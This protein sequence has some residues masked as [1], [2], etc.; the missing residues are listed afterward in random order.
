MKRRWMKK[1]L[2]L[3]VMIGVAGISQA[4]E[5]VKDGKASGNIYVAADAAKET[6]EAAQDLA[7]VF[8]LMSGA[9]MPVVQVKEAKDIDPAKTGI[10]IGDVPGD[11]GL[12]M[13]KSSPAGDGFV[14]AA[15]GNRL[16][17]NGESPRGIYL[18]TFRFLETLGCGWYT[19]GEMGEVIPK[20][21]SILVPDTLKHEEVSDAMNRRI[22]YGGK[23]ANQYGDTTRWLRRNN[24]DLSRAG[25]WSHF[26]NNLVPK[27][28]YFKDHPEYFCLW[29]GVRKGKQLCTTNPEVVKISVATLKENMSKSNEQVLPAG[30]NDGGGL[31]Q[32]PNCTA[33]DTPGY[34][35][36]SSGELCG[37]D[38]VFG[39]ANI[40]AEQTSKDFPDKSLGILV[41]SEYSRPPK[42]LDKLH[43]NVFPMVAPIRRCR[44][45]G[46]GTPGCPSSMMLE[47]EI[48]AWGKL[49]GK[50]GFYPYNYNLADALLPFSKM[51]Y[52]K[53]LQEVILK[54]NLKQLAWITESMDSWSANGPHI[55]LSTRLS[56]NSRIDID[57]EMDR[58]YQGL[59]GAA[60]GP[61]KQYWTRVDNA[62]ANSNVHTGSQYGLLQIWT[63]ELLKGCH[64]DIEAAKKA[65]SN[66]REKDAV[67]MAESGLRCADLFIAVAK[68]IN[69]CDFQEANAR[70][71]ELKA[72]VA[73]MAKHE[74]PSWA[75]ERYAWGYFQQFTGKTVDGGF[76]AL[77]N[78][79]KMLVELPDVWKFKKDEK[80]AGVN[81][82]WFKPDLDENGWTD[83]ATY[84][85]NWDDYGLGF[86]RGEA[87]YRTKFKC[88]DFKPDSDIRLWF[89][90]FDY[91]VD[92]WLNGTRLGELKGF[93]TPKEFEKIAQNLKPGAENVIAVRVSSGDL[94]ELGTGGIMKPVMIYQAGA[95]K[96][97]EPAKP[98]EKKSEKGVN[99]EM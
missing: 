22:W 85:K 99:Y 94:A 15:D 48:L 3:A 12:K 29:G 79:G 10:I 20:Q 4:L 68:A 7:K 57:K 69:R 90:G 64:D 78:G 96:A 46:P 61:M 66:A 82:Q 83:I 54:L 34:D 74:D 33:L 45:H 75:Q 5:L 9:E 84:T 21:P 42:K 76:K 25:T 11:A 14:Y 17:V 59:Y 23:N 38:R 93:A 58:F 87:W 86:Y 65:A 13:T 16:R 70:K 77:E 6:S 56:W 41:Y 1:L 91:N 39:F 47:E 52:Y 43:P 88:P 73:G 92:V 55:Y 26:W 63:D 98:G 62:Y 60:A 31:C 44:I 67:A 28:K 2:S 81:E 53:K 71:E 30:P 51:T 32:C 95:G 89:G 49:N 27:E 40:L 24:G 50:L 8:K 18:G 72:H 36:P 80:L 37:T 97:V 35:E 19:P